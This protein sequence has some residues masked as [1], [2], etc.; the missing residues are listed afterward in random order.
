M[1]LIYISI[2][3]AEKKDLSKDL[4]L[5]KNE[6]IWKYVCASCWKFSI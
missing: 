5:H 3:V 4:S 1:R 2:L 6:G